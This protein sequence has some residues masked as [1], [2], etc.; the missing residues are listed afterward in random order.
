MIQIF[1]R[2]IFAVKTRILSSKDFQMNIHLNYSNFHQSSKSL[3]KSKIDCDNVFQIQLLKSIKTESRT[4]ISLNHWLNYSS[5]LMLRHLKKYCQLYQKHVR[6]SLKSKTQ[7]IRNLSRKCSSIF[8]KTLNNRI[9][10]FAFV[11][12]FE[13]TFFEK[14]AFKS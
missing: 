1:S 10:F 2:W 8:Y 14:N 11:N 6:K 9:M 5:K 3:S 7:Y 4:S 13:M 12:I